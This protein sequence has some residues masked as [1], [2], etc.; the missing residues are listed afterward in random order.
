MDHLNQYQYYSIV[1]GSAI[2]GSAV[3][4][5][6]LANNIDSKYITSQGRVNK[7]T[8]LRLALSP[9]K[10]Y[11]N[12]NKAA[13]ESGPGFILPLYPTSELINN[14]PNIIKDL[15]EKNLI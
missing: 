10:L 8:F 9:E 15:S 11:V 5:I 13:G 3:P 2:Y 6:K 1:S 7:I 14:F 4:S 12:V